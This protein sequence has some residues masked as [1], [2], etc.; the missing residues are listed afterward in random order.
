MSGVL[1][2]KLKKR[3]RDFYAEALRVENHDL[4]MLFLEQAAQLY[5]KAVILELL[6]EL[7]RGHN[8]RELL[9]FLSNKLL[10]NGYE[11]EARLINEFV[12]QYRSELI[13]LEEAYTI[14]RYSA[15]SYDKEIVDKMA[16]IVEKL[17]ELLDKVCESVKL[18]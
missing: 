5:I 10:V 4:A 9:G 8:L 13:V 6:G 3:S 18:D 15:I 1:V 2:E 17:Y 16:K 12:A 7:V 11:E 14:A